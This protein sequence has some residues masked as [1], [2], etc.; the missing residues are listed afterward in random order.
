VRDFLKWNEKFSGVVWLKRICGVL[1][2]G[3][4]LYLFITA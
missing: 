1:I 3:G 2:I 4:G